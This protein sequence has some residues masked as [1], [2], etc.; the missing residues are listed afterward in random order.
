MLSRDRR[1]FDCWTWQLLFLSAGAA[2]PRGEQGSR[3]FQ[4]EV[5]PHGNVGER[6][7]MGFRGER[8]K[9]YSSQ[10]YLFPKGNA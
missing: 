5:G 1:L 7:P 10:K 2:G 4:G 9:G 6:G 3:G 8:G